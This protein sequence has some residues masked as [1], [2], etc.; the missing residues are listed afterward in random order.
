MWKR[1]DW[2]WRAN[3]WHRK[4]VTIAK[5]TGGP[6][7]RRHNQKNWQSPDFFVTGGGGLHL[8]TLPNDV[9]TM[10]FPSFFVPFTWLSVAS[11]QCTNWWTLSVILPWLGWI[12]SNNP[13][14]N[15]SDRKQTRE[16]QQ[17]RIKILKHIPQY[18]EKKDNLGA[19]RIFFFLFSVKTNNSS[20]KKP[21]SST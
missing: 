6:F 18:L 2:Q 4:V 14:Q 10:Q 16:G 5:G 9:R 7:V 12:M 19:K 13:F 15:A 8:F 1:L 20:A 21:W 3:R 17:Q 11:P